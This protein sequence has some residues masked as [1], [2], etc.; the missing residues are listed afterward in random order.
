LELTFECFLYL[1]SLIAITSYIHNK[2]LNLKK[3]K[4]Y[5]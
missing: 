2:H 5:D 1:D 3:K 4:Y